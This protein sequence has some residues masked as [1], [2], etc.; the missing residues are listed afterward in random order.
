MWQSYKGTF[1]GTSSDDLG[2][3]V[4]TDTNLMPN[5]PYNVLTLIFPNNEKLS[6]RLILYS[7]RLT[8]P[9]KYKQLLLGR[10]WSLHM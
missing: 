4:A 1:I 3:L 5:S 6:T 7:A 8:N 9:P 2:V 10:S